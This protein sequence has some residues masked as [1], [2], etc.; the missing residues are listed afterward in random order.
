MNS[1]VCVC[2]CVRTYIE[3]AL[4]EILHFT[5]KCH[6]GDGTMVPLAER[7][8]LEISTVKYRESTSI[9]PPFC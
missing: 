3:F 6:Q 1:C 9:T 7:G 2:V 5:D 8:T 4:K